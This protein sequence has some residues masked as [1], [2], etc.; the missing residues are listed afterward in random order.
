MRI[1]LPDLVLVVQAHVAH[2]DPGQLHRL[3]GRRA[4]RARL[5][6]IDRDASTRVVAWRAVN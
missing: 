2:P 6:D 5:A 1:F 4:E 3:E